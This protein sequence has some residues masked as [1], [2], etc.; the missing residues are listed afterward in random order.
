[1]RYVLNSLDNLLRRIESQPPSI[2]DSRNVAAFWISLSLIRR[3]SNC[4][5]LVALLIRPGYFIGAGYGTHDARVWS[6][7]RITCLTR[8][9]P[10]ST[11]RFLLENCYLIPFASHTGQVNVWSNYI[12]VNHHV[13]LCFCPLTRET[14]KKQHHAHTLGPSKY[15]WRSVLSWTIT[16]NASYTV[17]SGDEQEQNSPRQ[18]IQRI[19]LFIQRKHCNWVNFSFGAHVSYVLWIGRI[20]HFTQMF[21]ERALGG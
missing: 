15:A 20:I 19:N 16:Q 11:R 12:L 7:R 9:E 5:P 13:E 3:G 18:F 8:I 21:C 2:M 17:P 1:M 10:M 14:E 6:N 4:S